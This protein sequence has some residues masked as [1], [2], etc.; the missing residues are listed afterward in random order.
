MTPSALTPASS[1]DIISEILRNMKDGL[2]PLYKTV[3]PPTIYRVYLHRDDLSRISGIVPKII[4]EARGALSSEIAKM[5]QATLGQKLRI[6]RPRAMVESPA[7]D[8]IIELLEN[9]DQDT[10]P[11]DIVIYSELAL[12][13]K[14]EYSGSLTKRTET[15]RLGKATETKAAPRE[16]A[17]AEVYATIEYEDTNGR[18]IYE[19]T[20]N[21]IVIGRGGRDYWTDLT[22]NTVPDVS[23]EHLRL[24]RDPA[25][26]KFFLKDLSRLG[27]TINGKK[28][29]SS[30]EAGS[31]KPK[32]KNIEVELPRRATIGL[33]DVLFLE[34]EARNG[35]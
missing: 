25:T 20:K 34:F 29:P 26:G 14:P 5:N 4:D 18:Q 24:R 1:H 19:I 35:K 16:N 33:A 12:P 23:R 8:W 30:L 21:Q 17:G 10:Q 32:D 31:G 22:L 9:T 15:R 7:G 13:A 6:A 3:I 28:A 11:G 27:S 2:E